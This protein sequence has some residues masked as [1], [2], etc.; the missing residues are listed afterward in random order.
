M[1]RLVE[2][3]EFPGQF[4][5]VDLKTDAGTY[6]KE[7]IH[8]DLGRTKPNMCSLLGVD[9]DIVALDV[10]QVDMVWPPPEKLCKRQKIDSKN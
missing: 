4:F 6:I 2:D 1:A 5:T 8:G 3:V 7:F 10:S 9:V